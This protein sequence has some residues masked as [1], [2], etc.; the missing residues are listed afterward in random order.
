MALCVGAGVAAEAVRQ[1]LVAPERIR[2]IG[3]AVDGPD[4]AKASMSAQL[5]EARRRARAVLGLPAEAT[6]VG[7][8][9]RLPYQKAPEDFVPAIR[10]L[11][12]RCAHPVLSGARGTPPG[13]PPPPP[14]P[15]APPGS[16]PAPRS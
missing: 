14:P 12:R 2:T 10:D 8:V 7:A 3:V 5:P 16:S 9:G 13:R 15:T 11:D 1:E 4:R 6:V